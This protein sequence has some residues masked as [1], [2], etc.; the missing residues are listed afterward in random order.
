MFKNILA[1]AVGLA[2]SN[3][4]LGAAIDPDGTGLNSG[5]VAI[6]GFDWAPTS[7]L[8]RGGQQAIRNF[9]GN[10]G[11]QGFQEG[12][13]NFDLLTHARVAALLGP[14]GVA[15][16]PAG[17]NTNYEITMIMGFGEQVTNVVQNIHGPG[18]AL[19]AFQTTPGGVL[20]DGSAAF[21][22]M[23]VSPVNSNP[24]SGSGFNEATGTLLLRAS[25]IS[26]SSFG[27][28]TTNAPALDTTGQ[29]IYGDLDQTVGDTLDGSPANDWPGVDSVAGSGSQSTLVWGNFTDINEDFWKVLPDTLQVSFANISVATPFISV[30]PSD[31]FNLPGQ[32]CTADALADPRLEA[33]G[34]VI[35]NVG[36]VNGLLTGG[37]PDFVAQTDFNSPITGQV[38]EPGTLTLLGL[39]LVGLA[40]RRR[41]AA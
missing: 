25:L 35:P 16:T 5:T 6:S 34:P 30:D 18:S 41:M 9:L 32:S 26:S 21:F 23:Y 4:A 20:A 3:A 24:L 2:L 33:D 15:F 14:G 28:F 40:A 37:S 19:A 8:A 10:A 12:P 31:C 1:A 27:T 39:G 22:E 38:P 36:A 7:F 29:P 13:T 17:L 11:V